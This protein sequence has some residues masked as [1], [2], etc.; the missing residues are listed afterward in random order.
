MALLTATRT[1]QR[2]LI[3]EFVFNYDDTAVDSVAGTTKTFGSTFGQTLVLDAINMP[4]GAYI[5]GGEVVV[6]TAW[7]TST[8]ATISVGTSADAD[9]LT[10]DTTVDLKTS[11]R[12][13][14]T[15][16]PAGIL[17][18]NTGTNIR[19]TVNAT[20]ANAT[21][22][23]ARVRVMYTIDDRAEEVYPS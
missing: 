23:K 3:A 18:S 12:T 20:V 6:E 21:A 13:A 7:A 22:G 17:A 1:A 14:L 9:K 8:A 19:I 5:C 15:L 2:P 4:R 11:A 10:N 16:L